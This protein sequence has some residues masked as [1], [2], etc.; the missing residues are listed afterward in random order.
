VFT[1][2]YILKFSLMAL[3]SKKSDTD[4]EKLEKIIFIPYNPCSLR[5]YETAWVVLILIF[6][7]GGKYLLINNL[8]IVIT[9]ILTSGVYD[10]NKHVIAPKAFN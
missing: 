2:F 3:F 4:H 7:L 9:S 6:A 8:I 5:K 10:E 1:F